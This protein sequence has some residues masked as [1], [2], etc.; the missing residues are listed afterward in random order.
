MK[1]ALFTLAVLIMVFGMI[2]QANAVPLPTGGPAIA[3]T[4]AVSPGLGMPVLASLSIP[5]TCTDV[6]GVVWATGILNQWV[7]QLPGGLLVF[8]YQMINNAGSAAGITL[9]DT[10]MYIPFT[11]NVDAD[12]TG[13]SPLTFVRPIPG[14]SVQFNY[15]GLGGGGGGAATSDI[16]WIDTNASS[17]GPGG[18]QIQGVGNCQLSTYGPRIPEPAS[19]ML[20]GMGLIG[21]AGSV[22]R[23]KFMA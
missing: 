11:T 12:G 8:E 7:K 4:P 10:T 17:Y 1:K 21:F 23:R 19:A 18:T 15:Q 20:L 22:I 16:M 9:M 14:A 13:V 3:P 6:Q 5:F 2:G